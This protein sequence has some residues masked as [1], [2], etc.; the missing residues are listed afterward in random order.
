MKTKLF[1]ALLLVLVCACSG[2]TPEKRADD[3]L[4]QLKLE[5]KAS[6]VLYNSPGIE[7]LGIRPY[8]WWNEALHGVARN[9]S[10]T[11]FPQPIGRAASFD[12]ALLEEV[13]TVVSDEARIKHHMAEESGHYKGLTFWT[14]NIN[15]FRDPRWG[16]GMETYGEDPYLTGVLGSAVVRGLQGD[17]DAEVLKAHACAK[18]YAVH[19]GR[20]RTATVSTPR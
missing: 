9:G 20:K 3:L 10:A 18:H 4:S 16:R 7:R 13:F 8:N 5:E 1:S 17:P 12:E 11:V 2:Q 19:S 15:I 14:P 6:L